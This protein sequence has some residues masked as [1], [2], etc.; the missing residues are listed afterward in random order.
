MNSGTTKILRN[1]LPLA[2]LLLSACSGGGSGSTEPTPT[3]S[4]YT[5]GGAVT[6]L[7]GSVILRNND[8]DDLTITADGNF[9][10]VTSITNGSPYAV[11]IL[12]QP[13]GQTCSVSTGAGTVSGGNVSDVAVTCSANAYKVGGS[14]AGLAGTVVLQ[15]NN[16]DDLSVSADGTFTFTTAVADGSPYAVTVLTQPTGQ[17]CIVNTGAGTVAGSNVGNVAVVCSNNTFSLGGVV[18]GLTGTVI[19]R[20]NGGDDLT[21]TADG[22]F[23]F[24]ASINDGNDYAVSVF[25]QPSGQTCSVSTGSG[26]VSGNHVSNVEV[27]CSTN[28]YSV[29]GTVSGLSGTLVLQNNNGDDL[30]VNAD[31]TFTFA[32]PITHNGTYAVTVQTQPTGQTCSVSTGSGTV[33][34]NN[35]SNVAVVCATNS[36]SVGGTVS[37][38]SGTVVLQNNSGDDLAVTANSAFTFTAPVAYG[39]AYSVSVLTQPTGQSCS[40][41]NATSTMADANISDVSITCAASTYT[42]GGTVSGLNGSM[43]LQDN[44]ADD[45]TVSTNGPFTFPTAVAYGNP[46][47][48]TQLSLQ[49]PN[50]ACEISNGSG[51]VSANVSNVGVSC[52]KFTTPRYAYTANAYDNS[53]ST[54]AVDAANGRLK[55]IGKAATG[56]YPYSVTV[57]PSGKYAYVANW[58][59]NSVSQYTI[60]ADGALTAMA[61][62]TV[63]TGLSPTFITVDPSGKYAYVANGGGAS[64]TQYSIGADGALTTMGAASAGT[65]PI[66]VTVDPSGKYVYVANLH[67]NN[68]SQYTI[69]A[70]GALTAMAMATVAAGGYPYSVTVDPSGKYA[71]V[72][73]WDDNTVSQ[74]TIG[75]DGALK[76]MA[77]AAVVTGISP[78]F[79][80]VDPSGKYAY[81]V[82]RDDNS[83]SQYTI[84]ADGALKA[85]ATPTVVTG[86]SPTPVTVDPSGKYAYVAN[87]DD[88]SVSQYSIG[89]DGA[90]TPLSTATVA[91]MVGPISIVVSAGSAPVQA[92]AKYAYA[93]NVSGNTISQY[94]IGADG[95][96]TVMA[97]ASVA[98]GTAPYSVTVDPSGKYAYVANRDGNSVS[99]YNIGANGELAAMDI[100]SVAAGT[101]PYSVTVD[102]SGKYAYVANWD[103]NSVS[104]Y[105]IGATGALTAMAPA[106]VAS[107]LTPS[108][109]T[110][111][112][113][114]KYAYVANLSSNSISQYSI[115]AIGSLAP[116]TPATVAAGIFTTSV[117]VDPSGKYAYATNSS[118]GTVSQYSIGSDGALTAMATVAA[119]AYPISIT[120]DPSGKYAYVAN[121]NSNSVSQYSIGPEGVLTA[122][123]ATTVATGKWP[124]SVT[125][126]PSGKYAYVANSGDNSVSQYSIGADGALT[127]LA[128]AAAESFPTSI[129]TV[130]SYR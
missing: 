63:A 128:T 91:D 93:A 47:N 111:A 60:G 101:A 94:S 92:V 81:V 12:I 130:G 14:V 33:S 125:V 54:Y 97:A 118:D 107:G 34:A 24:A 9:T 84:G 68:V 87:R 124:I 15:D 69:G 78:I 96:L 20:N 110:V 114:G 19:L 70:D 121:T 65:N 74:Y 59:G 51:T 79:V 35:V 73:N 43:V 58:D 98:A 13:S 53:V 4:S 86:I 90:L 30:S 29:G 40:L 104:Q 100:T 3:L 26:T 126:D 72:A 116:M 105:T 62:A 56:G 49:Y 18:S 55:F 108:S 102:P 127:A 122:M 36:Y 50:Q 61:T 109:I 64:V 77:T 2:I 21:V 44:G 123:A 89:A 99:Q 103:G 32:T 17:A 39:S 28:S 71:Y 83:V 48:V 76:A 7:A 37:G 41:V 67:S 10:F 16:G 22:I 45:L 85:M 57:D 25:N 82:N 120:V 27:V 42:I 38:L 5:V 6:G 113:S 23:T 106:T 117:T 119:G 112:P 11:T 46:Y 31:G 52:A 66:S 129:T 8:G 80:T 1:V 115:G 95:T 88:N 75:A